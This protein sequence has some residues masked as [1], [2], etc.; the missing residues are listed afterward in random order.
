ME[1][2]LKS[3]EENFFKDANS[4]IKNKVLCINM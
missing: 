4:N 2:V 1:V 3:G